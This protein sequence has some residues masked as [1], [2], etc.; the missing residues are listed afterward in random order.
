MTSNR[1]PR[2]SAAP[3][4]AL[5]PEDEAK[6]FKI[7]ATKSQWTVAYYAAVVAADTTAR[8]CELK[9]LRIG[10]IKSTEQTITIQRKT[11]KTDAG[12]RIIP[13]TEQAVRALTRL[14]ERARKLGATEP[15][16]FL[17]PAFQDSVTRKRV[18]MSRV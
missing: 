15:N 16:H 9:G 18:K 10:D 2:I 11:T 6:L 3:E 12:C 8:S 13:L 4:E 17:F 14:L 7:A 1:C 5:F